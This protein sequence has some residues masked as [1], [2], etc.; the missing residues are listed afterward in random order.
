MLEKSRLSHTPAELRLRHFNSHLAIP[1]LA[2]LLK[3][4]APKTKTR[5]IFLGLHRS[6]FENLSCI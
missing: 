4:I 1:V 5:P 6:S 2:E 3:K